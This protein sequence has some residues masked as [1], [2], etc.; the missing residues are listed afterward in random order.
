[1]TSP[2]EPPVHGVHF[3]EHTADVGLEARAPSA[4]ELFARA[5]LGMIQL[6]VERVPA[7]GEARTVTVEGSD[8]PILLRAWL[9]ALLRW[10]E[11]GF[12]A[13][14]VAVDTLARDSHGRWTLSARVSGGPAG[15]HPLREIKGVTLHGLAAEAGPDGWY[16]RVIFDV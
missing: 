2:S 5:A 6:L 14:E 9:R 12:T 13:A 7:A 10:H 16:A 4:P 11:D 8:L 15:G 1:V 3:L